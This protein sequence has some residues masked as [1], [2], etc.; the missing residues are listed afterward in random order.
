M[1]KDNLTLA[2]LF[3][4]ALFN[5]EI[6]IDSNPIESGTVKQHDGMIFY[7][8]DSTGI[9]IVGHSFDESV[10][11]AEDGFGLIESY[12]DSYKSKEE[13]PGEKPKKGKKIIRM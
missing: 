3:L 8:V 12:I 4:V 9:P 11:S 1:N 6:T 5:I 10:M 2:I 7:N 13:T